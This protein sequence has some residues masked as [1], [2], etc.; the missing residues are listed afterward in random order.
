MF[1]VIPFIRGALIYFIGFHIL[2][3]VNHIDLTPNFAGTL[4]GITNCTANC[5]SILAPL[6]VGFIVSDEVRFLVGYG[7][8]SNK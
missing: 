2:L 7:G 3:Q 6:V 1:F 5:M 4:M 8:Y